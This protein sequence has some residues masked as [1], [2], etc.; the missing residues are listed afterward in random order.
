MHGPF[1]ANRMAPWLPRKP[2]RVNGSNQI[3]N[4][5]DQRGTF[6]T[7]KEGSL[8]SIQKK[9]TE[10][11]VSLTTWI[12]AQPG[13]GDN[14]KVS[15]REGVVCANIVTLKRGTSH[16][17]CVEYRLHSNAIVW[18]CLRWHERCSGDEK[19]WARRLFGSSLRREAFARPSRERDGAQVLVCSSP[20]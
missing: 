16:V 19:T 11:R 15:R 6:H 17:C 3:K 9:P 18:R 8:R 14:T 1:L 13:A 7:I 4:I 5:G 10:T 20:C 2:F 12:R